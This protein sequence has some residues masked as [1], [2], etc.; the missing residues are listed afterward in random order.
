MP[1]L[2][3]KV[4]GSSLVLQ[5][6]RNVPVS[7]NFSNSLFMVLLLLLPNCLVLNYFFFL[8]ESI[9]LH[10]S[11]KAIQSGNNIRIRG[12][13]Y[14]PQSDFFCDFGEVRIAK[15]HRLSDSEVVCSVPFITTKME[16]VISF[17]SSKREFQSSKVFIL[18]KSSGWFS[19]FF[20]TN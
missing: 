8:V 10:P 13:C 7:V 15:A 19:Q 20:F 4:T 9:S 5:M 14:R 12:L 18:G 1:E 6:V 3:I 17:Y 11:A 16:M 2:T